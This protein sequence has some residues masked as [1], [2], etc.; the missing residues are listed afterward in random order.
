[1]Y[2]KSKQVLTRVAGNSGSLFK[3]A[4]SLKTMKDSF[5]FKPFRVLESK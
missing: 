1:M 4:E 5:I 2:V 3:M